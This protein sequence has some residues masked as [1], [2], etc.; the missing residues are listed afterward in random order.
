VF[1]K[2]FLKHGT[3][4]R[5]V[6]PLL[7]RLTLLE[8]EGKFDVRRPPNAVTPVNRHDKFFNFSL[9]QLEGVDEL[10]DLK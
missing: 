3:Y 4:D 7:K 10:K 6:K 5:V 2:D 8:M 9:N 1:V